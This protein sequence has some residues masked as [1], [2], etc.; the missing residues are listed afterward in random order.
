MF[1]CIMMCLLF[2]C[3][4]FAVNG[5]GGVFGVVRCLFCGD[6]CSFECQGLLFYM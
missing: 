1:I 5:G 2:R 6:V 3:M 4:Q